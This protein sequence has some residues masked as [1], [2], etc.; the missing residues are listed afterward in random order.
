MAVPLTITVGWT[1]PLLGW[2]LLAF[3][4]LDGVLGLIHRRRATRS[5]AGA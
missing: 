2:S 4:V 3:L 1:F 5:A